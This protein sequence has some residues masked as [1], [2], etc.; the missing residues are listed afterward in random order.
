M[1]GTI[2]RQDENA[3]YRQQK[4][5]LV[6]LPI[7]PRFSGEASGKRDGNEPGNETHPASETQN[8]SY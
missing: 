2:A 4:I 8:S 5:P 7:K 6:R 1:V 3:K